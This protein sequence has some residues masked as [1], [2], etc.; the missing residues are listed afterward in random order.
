MTAVNIFTAVITTHDSPT[1]KK[2]HFTAQC[3]HL[4]LLELVCLK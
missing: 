1:F 3:F 4:T 2:G